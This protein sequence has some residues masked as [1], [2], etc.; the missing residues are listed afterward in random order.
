MAPPFNLGQSVTQLRLPSTK[1]VRCSNVQIAGKRL[2]AATAVS[3]FG[4]HIKAGSKLWEAKHKAM[5]SYTFASG[6]LPRAGSLPSGPGRFQVVRLRVKRVVRAVAS[7]N[8]GQPNRGI[9]N[10]GAGLKQQM[11]R[12]K[13]LKVSPGPTYG[14]E[15]GSESRVKSCSVCQYSKMLEDFEE[16]VSTEDKRHEVCRACLATL[17]KTSRGESYITFD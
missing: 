14:D 15:A 7:N 17:R 1:I 11:E 3:P 6:R 12:K 4:C 8:E 13:A 16:T 10:A 9:A 2:S 5:G